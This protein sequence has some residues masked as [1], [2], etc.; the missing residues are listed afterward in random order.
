MSCKHPA[1]VA[2]RCN[3]KGD[4]LVRYQI[5]SDAGLFEFKNGDVGTR[6]VKLVDKGEGT[7]VNIAI[8]GSCV[9][10][11]SSCPT[12]YLSDNI[13]Y[14]EALSASQCKNHT[15]YYRAIPSERMGLLG[16]IQNLLS[17]NKATA[18]SH[19][20]YKVCITQC[21]GKPQAEQTLWLSPPISYFL[22]QIPNDTFIDVYPQL[23]LKPKLTLAG[24]HIKKSISDEDR[25]KA[26]Q[27][28]ESTGQL[29]GLSIPTKEIEKGFSLSGSLSINE[30]SQITQYGVGYTHTDSNIPGKPSTRD[31]DTE[32]EGI[33]KKMKLV[34]AA[35]QMVEQ[36]QSG[37]Y[38]EKAGKSE[39]KLYHFDFQPPSLSLEGEQTVKVANNGLDVDGKVTLGLDPLIGFELK[40]DMLMA[41]AMYFKLGNVAQTVREKAA[42]LEQRVKEGKAGAY[43]GAEFDITLKAAL[44]A[45]GSIQYT[46]QKAPTYDFEAEVEMPIKGDLNARSGLRV[47][48]MEGAFNVNVE[49]NVNAKGMLALTTETKDPNA[50]VELVF[51]HGG[52]WAEV[53]IEKSLTFNGDKSDSS[54]G[55]VGL[56]GLQTKNKVQSDAIPQKHRWDWVDAMDKQHSPYRVT[57]I[58]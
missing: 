21:A 29:D 10:H 32:F 28:K 25:H 27:Y 8:E 53:N 38:T 55:D 15:L 16:A 47:W 19:T 2:C 37:L 18:L 4:C 57:V 36:I 33:K 35:T 49:S 40:L 42:E 54:N 45:K 51:Y 13:A 5:T 6:T 34:K 26:Y 56:D 17:E 9:N 43:A 48:M 22:G 20:R 24:K 1:G 7:S 50:R 12:G 11:L 41:A 46:P 30:G 44:S 3:L 31:L 39:V 14:S 58:G 52:I 23:T